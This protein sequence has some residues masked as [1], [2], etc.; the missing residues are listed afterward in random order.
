MKALVL[1]A[2]KGARMMPLTE[3]KPKAMVQLNGKPLLEHVLKEVEKAGISEC[4]IVIGYKGEKIRS[5]F[6]DS[7]KGMK[8]K[9]FVQEPQLGTAH[10]VATAEEW[11]KEDFLLLSSDVLVEWPLLERLSQKKG[12]AAVLSLRHDDFPERYGVVETDNNKV[13]K[14]IEKPDCTPENAFVNAGIYRFSPKIF[15][16]IRKT[17][18]SRRNEFELTDS[19]RILL[20]SNEKVGFIEVSGP[21][22]DI[23]SIEDLQ[24][25]EKAAWKKPSIKF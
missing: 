6:G 20:E 1:A 9:Y 10:A 19:I 13:K 15:E 16:A 8:L 18:K 21:C 3:E 22:L 7:Y 12:F 4:G 17:K 14:I 25:A 2:G 11:L 23:G 5:Y 24:R